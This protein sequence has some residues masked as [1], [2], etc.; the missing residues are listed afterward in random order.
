[1]IFVSF[2][3]QHLDLAILRAVSIHEYFVYLQAQAH[4]TNSPTRFM[5]VGTIVGGDDRQTVKESIDTP[6]VCGLLP[7][8]RG[9]RE[10]AIHG[11]LWN[12]RSK[13]SR[14]ALLTHASPPL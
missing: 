4:F 8:K 1:M 3:Y 14:G 5:E 13:P 9:S 6:I 11:L 10:R 2:I 7:F 12:I